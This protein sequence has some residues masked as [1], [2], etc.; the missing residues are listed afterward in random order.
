MQQGWNPQGGAP[1]AP[2]YG[3]PQAPGGSAQAP[4]QAQAPG[5]YVAPA[6]YQGGYG[7]PQGGAPAPMPQPLGLV[8]PITG[9]AAQKA[10]SSF[11]SGLLDFSF[12][13]FITTKV[14]KV[15]YGLWLLGVVGI[16]LAGFYAAIDNMF[17]RTYTHPVEGFMMLV[18][19]PLVAAIYLILGRV[20]MEMI[21]VFFRILENIVE[22]NRKTKDAAAPPAP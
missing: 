17:L 8:P 3:P 20:Y 15:L 22:L 13:N 19:T 6:P 4:G 18:A 9:A 16:A 7:P 11:L 12:T 2:Q 14:V 5:G 21:V 10:A 1:G